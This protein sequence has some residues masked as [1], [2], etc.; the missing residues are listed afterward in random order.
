M[1]LF[2][3]YRYIFTCLK[4][5]ICHDYYLIYLKKILQT[6]FLMIIKPFKNSFY[7]LYLSVIFLTKS[8]L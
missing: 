8:A 2:E 5:S 7:K 3:L 4:D 1:R 6:K